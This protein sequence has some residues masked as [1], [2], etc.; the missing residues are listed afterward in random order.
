MAIN[1]D[2][3]E[4]DPDGY[5]W[6]EYD[7]QR[8]YLCRVCEVCEEAKLAR[9]RPEILTGYTQSDV[10]EPIEPEPY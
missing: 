4:C 5:S 1:L 2:E 3:H 10:D 8:I 7:A 6:P 9:Y